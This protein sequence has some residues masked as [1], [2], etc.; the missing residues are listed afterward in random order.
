MRRAL[1]Q[2]SG[3]PR[4]GWVTA[5]LFR[6]QRGARLLASGGR[7][8]MQLG[9]HARRS[10]RWL[11]WDGVLANAS[12]SILGAYQSIYLLALGATRADIGLLS[13]LSNLAMPVAMA[14]GGKLA[15]KAHTLRPVI[16]WSGLLS[17]LLLFLLLLLPLLMAPGSGLITVAI[18]LI[19]GR[20]LLSNLLLPGWTTLISGIV[21]TQWRGRYFSTRNIL[22]GAGGFL[23]LLAV[24]QL[25]DRVPGIGGYQLAL[26]L[27]MLA[28]L[29]SVYAFS[30]IEAPAPLAAVS[31]PAMPS[32]RQGLKGQGR[33]VAYCVVAAVWNLTV[34]ISGPFFNVFLADEIRASASVIALASAASTLASL[35]GQRV[36][37]MLSDRK[38]SAW[39]QRVTGFW[40]P[41]VPAF[42]GFISQPWQAFPL[43][44]FSGFMWAGY[45]LAA[46]NLL[47]EMT[48]DALR[49]RLVAV[50]QAIVGI[51]MALGAALGGWIAQ[52]WGYRPVFWIS[53]VGRL[54]AAAV[55]AVLVVGA[56]PPPWLRRIALFRVVERLDAVVEDE[57][58]DVAVEDAAADAAVE[59][60]G[61]G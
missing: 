28:G 6:W 30:R 55:F 34:Q 49:P 57:A 12:E 8:T 7:W 48:P 38:G 42:W 60:G 52:V 14:P 15:S 10:L 3:G 4:L 58:A 23:A 20:A 59:E 11:V 37:G 24:G 45:N 2:V 39:V 51:G 9:P 18:A 5:P 47:L 16:F 40:I 50:Y 53:G 27:A 21:P 54:I 29:G 22:M 33:F 26:G 41:A 46:F 32:L 61:Q 25:I 13:S 19:V 1:R 17:R 36:F 35:P 44:L 31:G 56:N 43:Q